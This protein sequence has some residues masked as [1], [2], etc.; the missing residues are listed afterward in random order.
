MRLSCALCWLTW[1]R[2]QNIFK[3]RANDVKRNNKDNLVDKPLLRC[4]AAWVKFSVQPLLQALYPYMNDA[5][6]AKFDPK[7]LA[8]LGLTAPP[9]A[10]GLNEESPVRPVDTQDSDT[11]SQEVGLPSQQHSQ[12]LIENTQFEALIGRA[13]FQE[14]RDLSQD[15][16]PPSQEEHP[17]H[18]Q[19]APSPERCPP[20]ALQPNKAPNARPVCII[21]PRHHVPTDLPLQHKKDLQANNSDI[22]GKKRAA[23]LP[24]QPSKPSRSRCGR[25]I[26]QTAPDDLSL[27]N[28][29]APQAQS[30]DGI[31]QKRSTP[32]AVANSKATTKPLQLVKARRVPAQQVCHHDKRIAWLHDMSTF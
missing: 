2:V 24:L 21:K 13:Q 9:P 12:P 11:Q 18:H 10:H 1:S 31:R 30:S 27:P 25:I 20:P 23:D 3:N 14:E 8:Q 32:P 15:E 5:W 29:K 6:Q 28:Q 19:P 26:K 7:L 17:L 22:S 16:H 4:N